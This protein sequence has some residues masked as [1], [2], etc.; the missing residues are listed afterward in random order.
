MNKR[1]IVLWAVLS[2]VSFGQG[3]KENGGDPKL[4]GAYLSARAAAIHALVQGDKAAAMRA[5]GSERTIDA[6]VALSFWVV[7]LPKEATKEQRL[8]AIEIVQSSF[9]DATKVGTMTERAHAAVTYA[10][11]I[12]ATGRGRGEAS[13]WVQLA[14]ELD[15]KDKRVVY[16]VGKLEAAEKRD[17]DRVA[18]SAFMREVI[19]KQVVPVGPGRLLPQPPPPSSLPVGSYNQK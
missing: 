1:L 8:R 2:A 13:R 3:E 12:V 15:P 6:A 19:S 14:K 5:T 7:S 11:W 17:Q 16:A 4:E 10:D 18:D 9:V